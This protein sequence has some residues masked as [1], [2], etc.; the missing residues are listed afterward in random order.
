MENKKKVSKTR[1]AFVRRQHVVFIVSAKRQPAARGES[2]IENPK[3][4]R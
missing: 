3:F 1:P 2:W 4:E